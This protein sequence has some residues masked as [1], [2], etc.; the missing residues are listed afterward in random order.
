[1]IDYEASYHEAALQEGA[2]LDGE[3]VDQRYSRQ[4]YHRQDDDT[5]THTW[6]VVCIHVIIKSTNHK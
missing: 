2:G 4:Q 3:G 5:Y 1:M 6:T